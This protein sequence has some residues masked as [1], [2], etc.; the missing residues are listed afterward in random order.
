MRLTSKP[1]ENQLTS[2]DMDIQHHWNHHR[3]VLENIY[4]VG[5]N[6]YIED[7]PGFENAFRLSDRSVRCIDERTPGGLH[8]A[9][10]GILMD[11][12][13]VIRLLTETDIDGIFSHKECGAANLAFKLL[14]DSR[15][16]ALLERTEDNEADAIELF[17][18]E[19][20][21]ELADAVAVK[22]KGHL[23]VN[24]HGFHVARVAYYD[25]TGKFDPSKVPALPPGFVISRRLLDKEYSLRELEIAISIAT[26][27]HGYGD[28]ISK[29][30]PFLVIPIGSSDDQ[31]FSA[32]KLVD[33]TQK[34]VATC[35]GKVE[36]S[37]FIAPKV[38]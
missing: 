38:T 19:W 28:R 15:K 37:G 31:S 8:I 36:L 10:S 26:G 1:N 33:E 22:Y 7:L 14:D 5:F 20:A 35:N 4:R 3:N 2:T 32:Q 11:K 25:G 23:D 29:V 12:E 9:G 6:K 24:P 16:I 18:K 27:D 13:K 34:L 30:S 21:M 17:S